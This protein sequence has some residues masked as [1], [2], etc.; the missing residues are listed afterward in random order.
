MTE[1]AIA[2]PDP[3]LP[4]GGEITGAGKN[5]YLIYL[6]RFASGQSRRTMGGCLDRIAALFTQTSGTVP[7]GFGQDFPWWSLRNEHTEAMR[8]LLHKQTAAPPGRPVRQWS[9]AQVNKHL[10]ALRGV[11]RQA[12]KLGL[13]TTDNYT[14]AVAIESAKGSRVPVGRSISAEEFAAMLGAC[15]T[16]GMP[17]KRDAALIA[18][19]H[20]TGLRRS[21]VAA[22][23]RADY[24]AGA[25]SVRVI[26]KGNKERIVFVHPDAAR[27]LSAWLSVSADIRSALFCPV[28]RWGQLAD[29]H[30][31]DRSIAHAV[32]HRRLQA[33]LAPLSP[34]DFRRTFAG[35]LLDGGA[36]LV[37]VKGLLGHESADVTARYD[38]RPARQRQAAVNRLHLPSPDELTRNG[39][40]AAK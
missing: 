11:L 10:S 19:L 23:R 28:N 21:E 29:R 13:M 4:D 24:D 8:A 36:D 15:A 16:G 12:W 22:V 39:E 33:A 26:G 5:P 9:P 2:V 40:G 37:Q 35:D 27:Y 17:G 25:G 1:A 30:L 7:H 31:S 20:S 14:R 6:A 18:F 3:D 38:R 34:H 32:N